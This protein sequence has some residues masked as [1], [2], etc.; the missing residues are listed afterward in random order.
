MLAQF[1]ENDCGI[2]GQDNPGRR[3]TGG[4]LPVAMETR[5]ATDV[6]R[7]CGACFS[8]LKPPTVISYMNAY[9]KVPTERLQQRR[10]RH[11]SGSGVS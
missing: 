6:V 3:Q 7:I 5:A 10:L 9:I 4:Y 11:S 2:A 8:P 1:L